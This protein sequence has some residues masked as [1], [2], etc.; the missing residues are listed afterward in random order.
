MKTST[1]KVNKTDID[2]FNDMRK[3]KKQKEFFHELLKAKKDLRTLKSEINTLREKLPIDATET[4][5]R[6]I[7]CAAC[8]K[9]P[10]GYYVCAEQKPP[11]VVKI[12]FLEVCLFCWE[13]QQKMKTQTISQSSI[14]SMFKKPEKIYCIGDTLYIDPL[15]HQAKCQNC[16]TKTLK[17]W[18]ECQLKQRQ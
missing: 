13:K 11:K 9:H 8:L 17:V 18:A 7:K 4:D 1:I 15:K 14:P 2:L 12:P 6:D 10:D 3:N 5:W 16:N